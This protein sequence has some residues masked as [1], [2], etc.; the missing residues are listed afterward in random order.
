MSGHGGK[1]CSLSS[2]Y[3]THIDRLPSARNCV[4]LGHP[5]AWVLAWGVARLMGG[6]SGLTSP[7]GSVLSQCIVR[8]RTSFAEQG[9]YPGVQLHAHE[10]VGTGIITLCIV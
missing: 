1:R 6:G 8:Y 3:F 10:E 2:S 7:L 9:I 4:S 5:E